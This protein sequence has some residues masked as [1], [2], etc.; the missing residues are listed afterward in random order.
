V[1]R[2]PRP[3]GAEKSQKTSYGPQ[4]ICTAGIEAH[5]GHSIASEPRGLN[6]T[7]RNKSLLWVQFFRKAHS[8]RLLSATRCAM[9][10]A[11]STRILK[12][13]SCFYLVR[14]LIFLD[15]L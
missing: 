1:V 12:T 5:S 6:G 2:R 11:R 14:S 9:M 13:L 10:F 15:S 8:S 3:H 4:I 7:F